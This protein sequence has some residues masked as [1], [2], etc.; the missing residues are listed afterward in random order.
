MT[1]RHFNSGNPQVNLVR[2]ANRLKVAKARVVLSGSQRLFSTA[3]AINYACGIRQINAHLLIASISMPVQCPL[4][5]VLLALRNIQRC[6]TG[7]H[8]TDSMCR[9]PSQNPQQMRIFSCMNL[10]F[11]IH[12][13]GKRQ[14]N[15]CSLLHHYPWFQEFS[16]QTVLHRFRLHPILERRTR[17]AGLQTVRSM[18]LRY[19]FLPRRTLQLFRHLQF[20]RM[21]QANQFNTKEFSWMY[22]RAHLAHRSATQRW[23]HFDTLSIVH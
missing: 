21:F 17:Q 18:I 6:S 2:R 19:Q 10:Q 4:Q 13:Q 1:E 23:G 22:A 11:Q 16:L 3:N 9:R 5:K 7:I 15:H 12:N 14:H 20:H 8:H